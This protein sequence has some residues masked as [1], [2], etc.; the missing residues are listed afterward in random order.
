MTD[1]NSS[2]AKH[3]C[4]EH[5]TVKKKANHFFIESFEKVELI[6]NEHDRHKTNVLEKNLLKKNV[7]DQMP[8]SYIET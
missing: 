6:G 2:I 3:G 1:F 4:A 5:C 7:G 8:L